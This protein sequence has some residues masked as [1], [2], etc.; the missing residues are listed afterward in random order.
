VGDHRQVLG[1]PVTEHRGSR[2]TCFVAELRAFPSGRK[3]ADRLAWRLETRPGGKNR[4]SPIDNA[5]DR[6]AIR[7]RR[8][9]AEEQVLPS[10]TNGTSSGLSNG[11]ARSRQSRPIYDVF[12]RVCGFSHA[13]RARYGE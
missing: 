3:T 1:D 9:A 6:G 11:L 13:S 12:L 8:L 2:D 7:H 10:T 4:E 5:G